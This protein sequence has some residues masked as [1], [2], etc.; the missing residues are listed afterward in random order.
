MKD[1]QIQKTPDSPEG[2]EL[3]VHAL[4]ARGKELGE[5]ARFEESMSAYR[6]A[7]KLDKFQAEAWNGLGCCHQKLGQMEEALHAYTRAIDLDRFYLKPLINMGRLS[8][9]LE[10]DKEAEGALRAAL[11]LDDTFVP[12]Y[13]MLAMALWNQKRIEEALRFIYKARELDSGA[14]TF[15]ECFWFERRV[16]PRMAE[17]VREKRSEPVPDRWKNLPFEFKRK[18]MGEAGPGT[19]ERPG[20]PSRNDPPKK[21]LRESDGS[22]EGTDLE[23]YKGASSLSDDEL[24]KWGLRKIAALNRLTEADRGWLEAINKESPGRFRCYFEDWRK[25]HSRYDEGG[26]L[27]EAPPPNTFKKKH[28]SSQ[29]WVISWFGYEILDHESLEESDMERW[30]LNLDELSASM[31]FRVE[32]RGSLIDVIVGKEVGS[33]TRKEFFFFQHKWDEMNERLGIR[34][35]G[36]LNLMRRGGGHSDPSTH[37]L[38]LKGRRSFGDSIGRPQRYYLGAV[39]EKIRTQRTY[40]ILSASEGDIP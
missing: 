31:G 33:I 1:S 3:G 22:A 26:R 5:A 16:D 28:S 10:R 23:D 30:F 38:Y 25:K 4:I 40:K 39:R 27:K 15:R 19:G 34:M 2:E 24:R 29:G 21:K 6:S 14:A 32:R 35:S 36:G 9:Q 11:T 12:I 7:L 8:L 20:Q 18:P 13:R 17:W 37:E